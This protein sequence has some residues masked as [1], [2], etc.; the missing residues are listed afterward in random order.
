M[1]FTQHS[2]AKENLLKIVHEV[3]CLDLESDKRNSQRLISRAIVNEHTQKCIVNGLS[4][5]LR[6]ETNRKNGRS[7]RGGAST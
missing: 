7:G 3:R 1:Q 5:S 2:F 4:Q 6:R